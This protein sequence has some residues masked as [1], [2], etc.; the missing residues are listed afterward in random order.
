MFEMAHYFEGNIPSFAVKYAQRLYNIA[1]SGN[2]NKKKKK[3]E[4]LNNMTK[5]LFKGKVKIKN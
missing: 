4:S 2:I 1:Y 5:K 3:T